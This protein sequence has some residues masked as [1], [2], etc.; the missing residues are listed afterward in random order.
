MHLNS[1]CYWVIATALAAPL[2]ASAGSAALADIINDP[3]GDNTRVVV[4]TYH[5]AKAGVKL[6]PTKFYRVEVTCVSHVTSVTQISDKLFIKK[7]R[8]VS[9]TLWLSNTPVSQNSVPTNPAKL[10]NVFSFEKDST[11]QIVDATNPTCKDTFLLSGT[12]S[13]LTVSYAVN[14]SNTLSTFGQVIDSA[15]TLLSGII[16]IFITG[17]LQKPI[18][19]GATGVAG[20]AGPIQTLITALSATPQ[21]SIRSYALTSGRNVTT[22]STDY[23]GTHF[24]DVRIKVTPIDDISSQIATDD[25]LRTSFYQTLD[26][27]AST[28]LSGIT[29]ANEANQC[30]KFVNALQNYYSFSKKDVSFIDGYFAQSAFPA[31]LVDR[32][33]CIGNKNNAEDIV[34]YD[35][36]YNHRAGVAGLVPLTQATI[37]SFSWDPVNHVLISES[38]A[39][40]FLEGLMNKLASYAQSKSAADKAA[41]SSSLAMWM[42]SS[43]MIVQDLSSKVWSDSSTSVSGLAF[44]DKLISAGFQRFGCIAYRPTVGFGNFDAV[45]LAIPLNPAAKTTSNA[46]SLGELLGVRVMLVGTGKAVSSAVIT[47][48]QVTNDTTALYEAANANHGICNTVTINLPKG[49]AS[50]DASSPPGQ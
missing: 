48:A 34:N 44:A 18:V 41:N 21:N 49:Q 17:P 29:S 50:A 47:Q 22:I 32:M 40:Q 38:I 8:F 3:W 27:L 35:F 20:T 12:T 33:T 42:G 24:S 39:S 5:P 9:H 25:S 46:Y 7:S 23:Q 1:K 30:A 14:E 4:A 13:T 11:G 43:P 19:S 28:Y 15:A 10:I 31:S 26:G 6:T 36:F 16:P 2:V 37:D 45:F